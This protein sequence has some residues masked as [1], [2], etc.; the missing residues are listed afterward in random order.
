M[1]P[2]WYLAQLTFNASLELTSVTSNTLLSS[3]AVLFTYLLSVALLREALTLRRL[4][5]IGALMAGTAAVAVADGLASP[6]GRA[7]QS[8]LLG[9]A[10]CLVS[11]ALYGAYT[12]AI[13]WALGGDDRASMLLFFGCMGAVIFCT[14]GPA[15]A[16]AAAAGA[17]LG[18][19]SGTLL[20]AIVAKGLLDNVL[21]DYLWARSI[22]LIGEAARGEGEGGL[23]C[24]GSA[25]GGAGTAAATRFDGGGFSPLCADA[26]SGK[27]GTCP[28]PSGDA[29][30]QC[31]GPCRTDARD[32][33][34]VAADA[35]GGAGRRPVPGPCLAAQLARGRS[36][37]AGRPV[38]PG[39]V[40]VDD[41]G[42]AQPEWQPGRRRRGHGRRGRRG[43][44]APPPVGRAGPGIR[45]SQAWTIARLCKNKR[46]H[47]VRSLT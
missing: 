38:H 8:T 30:T 1:A 47:H 22:L 7:A 36:D 14:A 3:T 32:G 44:W 11:A 43:G 25:G 9:N 28:C 18:R 40:P 41:A 23:R 17:R 2:L 42:I 27:E 26:A 45:A 12:V 10:A 21:S 31:L 37:G 16:I 20:G 24:R 5:G 4:A 39:R 19:L 35:D 15:L 34:A 29:P 13:R 33:G 46:S 6:D